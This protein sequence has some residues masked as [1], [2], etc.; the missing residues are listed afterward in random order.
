MQHHVEISQPQHGGVNVQQVQLSV[1]IPAYNAAHLIGAQLEALAAQEFERSWEV[2]VADNGST[3]ATAEVIARYCGRLP[4]LRVVDASDRRGAAHAR[5]VGARAASGELIV[6]VDA[7]DVVAPGFVQA[8][9]EALQQQEFVAPR[10]EARSL[11][12]HWAANLGEHPQYHGLM[13][14]Y[15]APYLYHAGGC[16]L[17]IRRALFLSLGGFDTRVQSLEDSEFCFRAQLAGIRMGFAPAALIHV[18]NRSSFKGMLRQSRAWGAGEVHLARRY[19]SR[20]SP[21]GAAACW[22][23]YFAR[24]LKLLVR[25]AQARSRPDALHV[26]QEAARQVGIC[27]AALRLRTA[28]I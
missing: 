14:Y 10:L 25:L 20:V 9:A 12:T 24:W 5:N 6:F 18:R 28:P 2:I 27:E 21:P 17:G 1:V 4:G 15:N 13:R 26:A 11:N 3:D 23:R 19:R 7:D 8:M 16:G 22:G